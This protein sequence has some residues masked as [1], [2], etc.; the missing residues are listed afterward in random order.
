[1]LKIKL[2]TELQLFINL[3]QKVQKKYAL[4]RMSNHN[5][6]LE[7]DTQVYKEKVDYVH[8]MAPRQ[9]Y[10]LLGDNPNAKLECIS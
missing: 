6:K 4:F 5:P 2:K 1:M 9:V 7:R 10:I 8:F 3:P